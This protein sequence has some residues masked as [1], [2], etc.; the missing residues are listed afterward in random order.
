MLVVLFSQA[1]RTGSTYALENLN[2]IKSLGI[3]FKI[4][5]HTWEQN[6]PT[7]RSPLSSIY[8]HKFF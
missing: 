4:F 7:F 3:D 8:A 1:W 5:I 2:A 6:I